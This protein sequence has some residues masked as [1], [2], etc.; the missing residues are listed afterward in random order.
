MN[1]TRKI[2]IF[3]ALFAGF[4]VC[5]FAETFY[6]FSTGLYRLSEQYSEENY[7]R[8][9]DGINLMIAFNYYPD[10]FYLGFYV[11]T[12][13]GAIGKGYELKDDNM[14]SVNIDSTRDIRLSIG[15]SLK[16]QV[17]EKIKF[18]ISIGPI[19]TF[20]E[21]ENSN[22][23]SGKS[24]FFEALNFGV[25]GDVSIVVNP[26]GWFFFKSG[27]SFSWD[28]FRMERGMNTR[29]ELYNV[30]FKEM[31]YGAYSAYTAVIYMG[32]GVRFE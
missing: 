5:S 11:Q 7:G 30:Q 23:F 10:K 9:L 20:Y 12:F 21:E 24:E 2:V 28:L 29:R 15:P 27:I 6:S 16:L 19:V 1:N 8:E 18:P 26:S 31:K 32:I 13:I 22:N 3:L 25:L 4:A 14:D 17:G